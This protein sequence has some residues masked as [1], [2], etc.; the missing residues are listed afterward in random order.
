MALPDISTL[1]LEDLKKLREACS[2]RIRE[3]AINAGMQKVIQEVEMRGFFIS[4][5]CYKTPKDHGMLFLPVHINVKTNDKIEFC[6]IQSD[7][8]ALEEEQPEWVRE[9]DALPFLG[10]A[11]LGD[12]WEMPDRKDWIV[13]DFGSAT[14]MT[15]TYVYF[16]YKITPRSKWPSKFRSI[17]ELSG[18]IEKWTVSLT[19]VLGMC[20]V[21]C[22]GIEIVSGDIN[23]FII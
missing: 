19:D 5:V 17:N 10:Q 12:S 16:Y 6:N 2:V 22:N 1:G 7:S 20:K 21:Y 14:A 11:Q 18:D 9:V 15:T 23:P 8:W 4:W 3:F 13:G